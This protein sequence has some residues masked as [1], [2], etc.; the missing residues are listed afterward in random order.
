MA[1]RICKKTTKK[2]EYHCL[3]CKF[4]EQLTEQ[5]YW[6][7]KVK[8]KASNSAFMDE[9]NAKDF[10][11]IEYKGFNE[12][13]KDEIDSIVKHENKKRALKE[14]KKYCN[15]YYTKPQAKE[16]IQAFKERNI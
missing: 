14:Y 10:Y 9:F 8:C 12:M 1:Y 6:G 16:M 4:C 15:T 7:C 2:T 5:A 13:S 3:K 11:C